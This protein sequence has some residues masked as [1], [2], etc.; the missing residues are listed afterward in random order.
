MAIDFAIPFLI[1][2]PTTTVLL[3]SV[4]V[5]YHLP[6]RQ[7][8]I[9]QKNQRYRENDIASGLHILGDFSYFRQY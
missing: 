3:I 6:K 7:W 1:S 4:E 5:L 9:S 2:N 8:K